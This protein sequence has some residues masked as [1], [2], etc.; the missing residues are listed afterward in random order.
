MS[1]RNKLESPENRPMLYVILAFNRG[2]V[3]H[4]WG[5]NEL[6]NK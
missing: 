6:F 2:G 5:E 4:C 3:S 1:Q